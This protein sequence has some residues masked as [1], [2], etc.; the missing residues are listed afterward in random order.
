MALGWLKNAFGKAAQEPWEKDRDDFFK[1]IKKNKIEQIKEIAARYPNEALGWKTENGT[2]LYVAHE[3][4][5]LDSFK[6]LIGLGADINENYTFGKGDA[7]TPLLRAIAQK[8]PQWIEYIACNGADINKQAES[9]TIGGTMVIRSVFTPLAFAIEKG[10]EQA[11]KTL[12]AKG[13]DPSAPCY[14]I[15]VGQTP[16]LSE[17]PAQ[18]AERNKQY[19]IADIIKRAVLLAAT[20][21]APPAAPPQASAPIGVMQPLKIKKTAAGATP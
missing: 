11:V 7:R 20:A 12:L 18:Y 6:T 10:D 16:N 13:V 15:A 4:K 14:N 8:Q 1:A 2:P 21:P 9:V 19:K 3:N 17:L 5:R